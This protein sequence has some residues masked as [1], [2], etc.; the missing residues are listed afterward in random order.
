MLSHNVAAS[1][2]PGLSAAADY[3]GYMGFH[4]STLKGVASVPNVSLI[5][6]H[7]VLFQKRTEL[8]LKET[9]AW[10]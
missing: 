10:C 3:P 9:L 7:P 2:S 5:K 4:R 6:R 8:I 1:Y